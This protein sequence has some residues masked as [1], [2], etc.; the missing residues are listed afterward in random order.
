M[1]YWIIILIILLEFAYNLT[2]RRL[3]IKASRQPIP[4]VLEGIYDEAAYKRQQEY[5]STKR[6][7]G[8][9]SESFG[10]VLSLILFCGG[11]YAMFD[12]WARMVSDSPII[13]ALVFMGIFLIISTV[14]DV[15]FGYYNT[16]VIETRFGFNK[17]TRRLFFTDLLK[18]LA[19]NTVISGVI[20]VAVVWLYT[21]TAQWFWL[22]AWGVISLFTLFMQFF[23]SELIVPLFN[24]QT[25]LPEGE[26]RTAIEEFAKKAEFRLNNIY[27]MDS[28]KR[29]SHGNAYFTGW[30]S[31]KR[32]VLYDSLIQQLTTDEIVGV[33]AHEIGH[34][35]K[36][37]IV[38][39]TVTAL[40]M[41][42]ITLWLFSLVIDSHDIAAAA[43]CDEPSFHV[44]IMVFSMLFSPITILTGLLE[45]IW[46]RR[47][48]W[49]A[50]E[51]ACLH[52]RGKDVSSALK[53]MSKHSLSNLTPHPWV[54]FMEYSHPTL[55]DR[56]EHLEG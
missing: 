8:L 41:N 37:H 13:M 29:S 23:Y 50:D 27:M 52:G 22:L 49:E 11:F 15:P 4:K 43:G 12:S 39:S 34:Y 31:K 45:N 19:L 9:I 54:V 14:T 33:L 24:K 20:L 55:K 28:S 7:F 30:G 25:P 5:T 47:H 1:I 53:A 35:K 36:G 6:R 18:G 10:V 32:I 44:N 51:F 26:L 2:L 56:V 38:K 16:F 42:L 48:E 21:L 3:N 46:S 17:M 40:L